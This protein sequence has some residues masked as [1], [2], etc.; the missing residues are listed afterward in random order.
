EA[1]RA[2]GVWL[3]PLVVPL[4]QTLSPSV[5]TGCCLPLLQVTTQKTSHQRGLPG[6]PLKH[7][8]KFLPVKL[9]SHCHQNGI[10]PHSLGSLSPIT[11]TKDPCRHVLFPIPGVW[12]VL[13]TQEECGEC[14]Q[15]VCL[16][17][18]FFFFF[19]FFFEVKF[20]SVAQTGVQWR[21]LGSLQ[22]PSLRFK[23]FSSL[24][25]LSS[26]DYRCMPPCLAN[27]CIFS[28]NRFH[29][30]GQAGLELLTP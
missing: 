27:F 28:R 7:S 25:L 13:G 5:S 21:D 4:L 3:H 8:P 18:S 2:G 23:R 30:V 10:S 24:S 16:F 9:S 29:H 15:T 22:P 12:T 26:W 11:N 17:L 14:M 1:H 20:H 6:P 19:F